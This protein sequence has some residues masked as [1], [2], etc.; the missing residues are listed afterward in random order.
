MPP[1]IMSTADGPYFVDSPDTAA[2]EWTRRFFTFGPPANGREAPVG[3]LSRMY[4]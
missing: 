3:R 4:L 2:D 1:E